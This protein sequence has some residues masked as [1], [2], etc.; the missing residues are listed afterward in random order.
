MKINN[1]RV[2]EALQVFAHFFIDPLLDSSM[3]EREV[4]AVNSE[5]EIAV[6]GDLWKISHLFQILSNKPIGRFTIGS[7]KTLKDPMKEL[8]KFHSQ[9]YSANI[10]SLVVKSNYPDMAKWIRE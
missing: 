3:V 8:V 2:V 10:M 5:Y 7:L 6:S 4:N 9:Y 1:E